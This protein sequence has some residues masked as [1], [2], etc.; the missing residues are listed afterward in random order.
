MTR[1]SRRDQL[2]AGAMSR[3]PAGWALEHE[4]MDQEACELAS[5]NATAGAVNYDGWEIPRDVGEVRGGV[6]GMVA[7][8]LL[9]LGFGVAFGLFIVTAGLVRGWGGPL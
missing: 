3:H 6:R 1:N 9:A 4:R 7:D 8:G 5:L 2:I